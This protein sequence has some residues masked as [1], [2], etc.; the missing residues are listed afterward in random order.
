M[1]AKVVVPERIISAI[2]RLVPSRTN[3]GLTFL[4]S[5]GK[6]YFC[7]HSIS[8][9]SSAMPRSRL[10]AACV[11]VFTRPGMSTEWDRS[12]LRRAA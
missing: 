4:A 7:S 10:M 8:G 6:M 3:A 1:S 5:A 11:C 9:R 12:I 2:A